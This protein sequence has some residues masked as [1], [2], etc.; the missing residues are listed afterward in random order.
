MWQDE[1]MMVRLPKSVM[2]KHLP[3]GFMQ[4]GI[5]LPRNLLVLPH[6]LL[7]VNVLA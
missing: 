6:R 5:A 1:C 2:T 4:H 3:Y 7:F